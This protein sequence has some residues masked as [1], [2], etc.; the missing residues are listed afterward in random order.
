MPR[1]KGSQNV[2]TRRAREA[3]ATF[4]DASFGKFE[5][6]IARVAKHDPKGAADLYLRAAEYHVPKAPRRTEL[7]GADG[8]KL[9][10]SVQINRTVKDGE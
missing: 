7:T 2:V 3:F 6:W 8:E 4:V 1:P 5:E 9:S 10:V